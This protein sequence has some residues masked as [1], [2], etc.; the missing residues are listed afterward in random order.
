MDASDPHGNSPQDAL[1]TE[2]IVGAR[3][4]LDDALNGCRAFAIVI[5]DTRNVT[6]EAVR[7]FVSARG[8]ELRLLRLPA[9]TD[10]AHTFLQTLLIELG[11]DPIES[12]VDDLQRLLLV[13]FRQAQNAATRSAV[14]LDQAQELGPRVF[15]ALR[16]LA[17]NLA[18]LRPTPIF[19]LT[20]TGALARVLDSRGMAAIAHLTR[21]RFDTTRHA[22]GPPAAAVPEPLRAVATAADTAF[23]E[24]ANLTIMLDDRFVDRIN[25][26]D[27]RIL[28]GRSA[29]ND[30]NLPGRYVSRH[31]AMLV[32]GPEGLTLM[33]LRSTNGTLV[34]SRAI[35]S[36][37]LRDGDWMSIGNYR[38]RF[39]DPR[40]QTTVLPHTAID[41]QN[42]TE[43]HIMRSLQ[44]IGSHVEDESFPE[45]EGKH[46]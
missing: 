22:H 13:V 39:A 29:H 45:S 30:I 16:D 10:S 33:D 35:R 36:R 41:P 40:A 9:P 28:I 2:Q 12:T 8:E 31:H 38:L 23:A 37:V 4:Y 26:G 6:A 44:G 25:V 34:N 46:N 14:L 17:R 43:T 20:G 21:L 19:I 11:F 1:A 27:Q 18:T 5:S 24:C 7:D 32:P 42:L 15:E 3:A